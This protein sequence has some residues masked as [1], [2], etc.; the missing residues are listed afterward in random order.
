MALKRRIGAP[1]RPPALAAL[2][3]AVVVGRESNVL[4]VAL[5][6]PDAA[7]MDAISQATGLAVYP[8]YSNAADLA[9]TRERLAA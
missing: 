8:V 7:A 5:P 4:T 3:N 2:H 1:L 6:G 9:A